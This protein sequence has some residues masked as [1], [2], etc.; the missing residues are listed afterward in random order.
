MLFADYLNQGDADRLANTIKSMYTYNSNPDNKTLMV[1]M[2][3]GNNG[4]TTLAKFIESIHINVRVVNVDSLTEEQVIDW[5]V[6]LTADESGNL[7]LTTDRIISP[8]V[9]IQFMARTAYRTEYFI[10][11]KIM[12]PLNDV[13]TLKKR[14]IDSEG[15]FVHIYTNLYEHYKKR[16]EHTTS[17]YAD[18]DKN[19]Y[20]C[21]HKRLIIAQEQLEKLKKELGPESN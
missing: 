20:E 3:R 9:F 4:K 1:F 10:F 7:I 18:S 21:A 2:G 17:Q 5:L 13:D 11:D 12:N 14:L 16:Y 15:R 19:G 8:N 6:N